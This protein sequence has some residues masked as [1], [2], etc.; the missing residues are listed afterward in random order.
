[1]GLFN[2]F[3][4][5]LNKI[6]ELSLSNFS[7]KNNLLTFKIDKNKNFTYALNNI[8]IKNTSD[9]CSLGS[10]VLKTNSIFIE[11]IQLQDGYSFQADASSVYLQFFQERT[12]IRKLELLEKKEYEFFTF[13]TF[14]V[15]DKYF[16]NFIHIWQ[17]DQ[18][19]FIFD[20]ECSLYESLRKEFDSTY[21]YKFPKNNISSNFDINISLIEENPIFNYIQKD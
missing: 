15:D 6:Q 5:I 7:Y 20:F 9:I 4:K 17:V 3:S 13:M 16:L 8:N 1:M 2:T 10:Y 12:N 11:N 14:N 21:N 18:D 19:S